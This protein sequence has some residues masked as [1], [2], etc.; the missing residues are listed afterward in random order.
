LA[1]GAE[2]GATV[3]HQTPLDGATANGAGFTSSMSNLEIEMG[4]AQLALRADVS[5]SA[6]VANESLKSNLSGSGLQPLF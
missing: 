6:G 5:I 1:C 3:L 2:I 4:C